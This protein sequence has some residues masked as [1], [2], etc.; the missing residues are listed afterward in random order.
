L[1]FSIIQVFIKVKNSALSMPINV[2]CCRPV[3][4]MQSKTAKIFVFKYFKKEIHDGE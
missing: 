2:A 4:V 3:K 1:P